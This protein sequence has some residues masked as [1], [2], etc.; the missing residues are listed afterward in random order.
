TQEFKRRYILETVDWYMDFSPEIPK[1]VKALAQ[2]LET[3]LAELSFLYE[4]N[5]KWKMENENRNKDS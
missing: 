3:P 4:P 5:H 2:S 1:A